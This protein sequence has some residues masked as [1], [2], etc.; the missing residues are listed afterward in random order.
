MIGENSSIINDQI[1]NPSHSDHRADD[2]RRD[3]ADLGLIDWPGNF[4]TGEKKIAKEIEANIRAK[5]GLTSPGTFSMA[6][7][8]ATY[9]DLIS[10]NP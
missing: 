7:P 6:G 10:E 8:W 3:Y 9:Y 4:Y 2:P 5:Y 1:H